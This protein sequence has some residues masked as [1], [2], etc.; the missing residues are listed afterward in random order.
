MSEASGVGQ[1]SG[2]ASG[3]CGVI[4]VDCI[5]VLPKVGRCGQR[6]RCK[7]GEEDESLEDCDRRGASDAGK[8]SGGAMQAVN[9]V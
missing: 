4:G 2:W 7:R 3:W 8:A 5:V 6:G 9:S 1:A